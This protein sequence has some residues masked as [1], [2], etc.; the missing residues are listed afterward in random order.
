MTL[1]YAAVECEHREVFLREK[2]PAM[3]L[4]SSK[5]TVPVLVLADGRVIDESAD[6]MRWALVINDPDKWWLDKLAKA[7]QDLLEENDF[8]FK[9]HLDRYKYWQR[10]PEKPRLHYR[11]QGEK[12]LQK[13]ENC[14]SKN[15]YLLDDE[16][17]FADVA[18]FPFVRQF[19]HADLSWFQQA[20][21]PKLQIWLNTLLTS[22]LFLAVMNKY[23]AWRE[24]DR[25]VLLLRQ[26][27]QN[28]LN[29]N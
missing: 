13:L 22:P 2:P 18:I 25:P 14:L 26:H 29:Q 11:E 19:A 3:L 10:F 20:A 23:P 7:S 5:G 21:Y 28:R 27:R 4:A 24:G 6:V 12:F 15:K 9:E 16:L 8:S 1:T 17:R